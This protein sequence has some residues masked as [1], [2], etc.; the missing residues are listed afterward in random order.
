M[1]SF[2]PSAETLAPLK[3]CLPPLV[4]PEK[5]LRPP[6]DYQNCNFIGLMETRLVPLC[7][8]TIAYSLASRFSCFVP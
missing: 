5:I 3:N 1:S 4:R 8:V 7:I 2:I 6:F